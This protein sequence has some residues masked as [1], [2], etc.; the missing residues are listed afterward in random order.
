M[1]IYDFDRDYKD[2]GLARFTTK[3]FVKLCENTFD[4]DD[5]QNDVG[6][7]LP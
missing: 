3:Y 2:V 1:Q 4:G 5:V 7:L 6:V